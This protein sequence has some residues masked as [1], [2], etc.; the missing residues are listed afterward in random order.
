MRGIMDGRTDRRA[1]SDTP[2]SHYSGGGG[3]YKETSLLY[4][5]DQGLTLLTQQLVHK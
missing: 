2:S 4:T 5:T 1:D 3:G